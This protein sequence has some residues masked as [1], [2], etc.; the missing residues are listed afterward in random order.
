MDYF[1][2]RFEPTE[3]RISKKKYLKKL[4]QNIIQKPRDR[5]CEKTKQ[6]RLVEMEHKMGCA[7]KFYL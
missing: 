2:I 6:N 7:M 5:K 1:G 4:P 3:K